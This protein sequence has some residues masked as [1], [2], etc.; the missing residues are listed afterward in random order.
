MNRDLVHRDPCFPFLHPYPST[1]N[2]TV[3][4]GGLA[5][6]YSVWCLSFVCV[7][8]RMSISCFI[9]EAVFACTDRYSDFLCE[10]KKEEKKKKCVNSHESVWETTSIVSGKMPCSLSKTMFCFTGNVQMQCLNQNLKRHVISLFPVNEQ[11]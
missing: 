2:P 11:F 1:Q 3:M 10:G 9:E 7:C 5:E 8:A 4:G 6:S